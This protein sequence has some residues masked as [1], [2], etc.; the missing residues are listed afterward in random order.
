MR[1]NS[2]VARKRAHC[3]FCVGRNELTQLRN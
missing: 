3:R 2:S 1:S